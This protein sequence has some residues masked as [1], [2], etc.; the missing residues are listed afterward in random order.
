MKKM[1]M[2]TTTM[3]VMMLYEQRKQHLHTREM[4]RLYRQSEEKVAF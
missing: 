2:A 3:V 4:R 1:K